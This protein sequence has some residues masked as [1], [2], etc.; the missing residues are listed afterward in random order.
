[1][2]KPI[3]CFDNFTF[4]YRSQTEPTLQQINL[5]IYEG[6]KVLIVGPSGSGKSTL[7]HCINGLVPFSYKGDIEGS[8]II[9]DQET[10]NL[11]IFSLSKIVGTVLQDLDG[12]FI[13]LSV[14][15]DIAFALENDCIDQEKMKERVAEVEKLVDLQNYETSA[16]HTLSGGQKQ[17]VSL[18][19][20]MVDQVDVLLFDE[21][22]A[23]LDPATGKHAIAL[24]DRIQKETEK[25]V[26]IIEHRLEDVLYRHVDRIIVMDQGKIVSDSTPDELLASKVLEQCYI[27]E[28][29]YVKALKYAGCDI[30]SE[31]HIANEQILD[32]SSCKAKLHLWAEHIQENE[33][34]LDRAPLLQ[35]EDVRFGYLKGKELIHGISFTV[36]E[37]ELISIVGKNGAGKSTITK[38]ICGFEKVTSGKILYRGEDIT[39]MSIKS[40]AERIG[41]VMQ[42]PNEMISKHMI[43]DEVALGLVLRN[44]PEAEIKRRVDET[45]KI[46]GLYPFRNWPISALSFGQ[47]K[48]VTIASIL[49]LNPEI[50]ILDEPTAGQDFRHYTEIMEFL[51]GLN[52]LGVT[53]LMITHDMH[54]M[55]EYT[56]RAIVIADGKVIADQDAVEVLTDEEIIEQANLKKTSLFDLAVNA[57]MQDPHAFI[58][59]FITFDR[60]VRKTWQ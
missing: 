38:L 37:G 52:K 23:S 57:G 4:K 1:M 3:I 24:I 20:V 35:L 19:G 47:K 29:L 27:R 11:N 55:L 56:P 10:S 17:R 58:R 12:Q 44:V 33:G 54:L 39:K 25:T 50:L 51:V 32:I 40:R 59:K 8:L 5:T 22:L 15:E 21:P 7:A 48:R 41:I 42:N 9:K 16:V 45:L 28:P 31:M 2:K 36:G 14:G 6:E 26:V 13:G 30:T 34:E 46:C 18:A 60:E 49:V 53:I 43:Y